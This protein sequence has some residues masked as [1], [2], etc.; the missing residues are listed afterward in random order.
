[1]DN[2]IEYYKC[3]DCGGSGKVERREVCYKRMLPGGGFKY[4]PFQSSKCFS[5]NG[6]GKLDWI[7][8][9]IGRKPEY[10]VVI[11]EDYEK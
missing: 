6:T 5:C 3:K 1:M 9:V 8:N 10:N 2:D 11:M 4:N 7:E